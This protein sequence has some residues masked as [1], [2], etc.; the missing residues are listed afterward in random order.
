[1]YLFFKSFNFHNPGDSSVPGARR[2]CDDN[3]A[4]GAAGKVRPVLGPGGIQFCGATFHGR[5][6]ADPTTASGDDD[7]NQSQPGCVSNIAV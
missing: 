6:T 3:K 7:K 1:L 2:C 4:S 5:R